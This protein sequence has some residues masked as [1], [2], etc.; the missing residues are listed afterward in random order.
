MDVAQAVVE[1]Q[2]AK[3]TLLEKRERLQ[4]AK[5]GWE[6]ANRE[7]REA[8]HAYSEAQ[9]RLILVAEG[10]FPESATAAMPELD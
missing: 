7:E 5:E 9:E 3:L 4:A 6:V 2:A 8:R 1:L 10:L